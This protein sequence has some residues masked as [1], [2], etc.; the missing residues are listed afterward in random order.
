VNGLLSGLANF[1][2]RI[3]GRSSKERVGFLEKLPVDGENNEMCVRE[4][5]GSEYGCGK[6]AF[7]SCGTRRH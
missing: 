1:S 7:E 5:A 6:V 4:S 3:N 2:R